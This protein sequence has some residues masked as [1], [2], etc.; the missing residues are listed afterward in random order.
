MT[1]NDPVVDCLLVHASFVQRLARSL[2]G[3]DGDDLAQ[4]TFVAVLAAP[5]V[6]V[7]DPRGWLAAIASNL[8][9]NR[10]RGELRR[11]QREAQRAGAE[12]PSVDAILQREEV[13][14]R[15]VAA[16]V[17][18]PETL[19]TVVLLRYFEGLDSS[20]I[21]RKLS[22]PPSTVRARLQQAIER[23]R[24]RL[25]EVHGDRRAAWAGPVAALAAAPAGVLLRTSTALRGAVAALVAVLL[26]ALAWPLFGSAAAPP[27]VTAGGPIEVAMSARDEAKAAEQ[28]TARESLPGAVAAS[29]HGPEDFWGRVV[30]AVDDRA[31]AGAEVVLEHRDAD[32]MICLD[33]DYS[34]QSVTIGSARTDAAGRFHF[35]VQRAL[36][37]RLV[38]R[39]PGFAERREDKC[40]GGS[41]TVVRLEPAAFVEGVVRKID[42]T[43]LADVPVVAR[44]RGAD[45][46]AASTRTTSDGV[47]FLG[48]L[49]DQPT[50]VCA[51][52]EGMLFPDWQ[53]VE[54]DAGKGARVEFAVAAGRTVR[55]VVRDTES[56]R[57]ISGAA[58]AANWTMRHAV[59][60]AAD[61]SYEFRGFGTE[62]DLYVRADGYA[63]LVQHVADNGDVARCDLALLRGDTVMGRIVD[64]A[65]APIP[66]AYVAAVADATVR[67]GVLHTFW[68]TGKVAPDGRF[69]VDGLMESARAIL[70]MTDRVRVGDLRPMQ[71]HLL[72][73]A[74][75]FGTRVLALPQR[76]QRPAAFDAGAIE[77]EPQGLIEGRVVDPDARPVAGVPVELRGQADRM[78]Q[79][80][81]PGVTVPAPAYH[82][83]TRETRTGSDGKY[84]FAGVGAGEYYGANVTPEG[85]DWSVGSG[86]QVVVAGAVTT[87]P[88]IVLDPGLVIAGRVRS[89]G[90]SLPAGTRL[91]LYAVPEHETHRDQH[92]AITRRDGSFRIERLPAGT[93]CLHAL[94]APKGTAIVPRRGVTAGT[95]GLEL[96]LVPAATIE[97]CVVGPDGKARPGERLTFFPDG[98]MLGHEW[99]TGA[100]GRFR[101]ET[102]PGV[103]GRLSAGSGI[104]HQTSPMDVAAGTRD[105]VLQ[106]PR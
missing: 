98:F 59:H 55:G 65:N 9:R 100:D 68:R 85:K 56:G 45:A 7:R 22:L 95:E 78:G 84:R 82:L 51:E 24:T 50:Y 48:G 27:P 40:T 18:L 14:R 54:L 42:G 21:G 11:A 20:A 57:P 10:R 75:A 89:E 87:V 93:Y 8:W 17:A 1:S 62:D 12:A 72:V 106:L 105:L 38:V 92:H 33:L 36:Q 64:E 41:E 37:H 26:V 61:G 5:P 96:D 25:D 73:R 91:S 101:I 6:D 32:E 2:A 28:D 3:Q 104:F 13:R 4:E 66:G 35:R 69:V 29:E 88:D 31:L 46:P 103:T 77:L 86:R 63:D 43:P 47:F 60:S 70:T 49:A 23:L 15:V 102:A 79:L 71:W 74:P 58:I 97:G 94:D 44:V 16:V 19:R 53:L 99:H 34:R 30:A 81:R 76:P 67:N 80:L 83:S 39:A 52:P 90:V